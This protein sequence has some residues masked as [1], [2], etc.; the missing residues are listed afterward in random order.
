ML[1][2]L[3]LSFSLALDAL[4]VSIAEGALGRTNKFTLGLKL[5]LV[6]GFF[7]AGM[8]MLG[9]LITGVFVEGLD[10]ID[11]WI[12]FII[13]ILLGLKMFKEAFEKDKAPLKSLSWKVLCLLGIATS[14]DALAA[15]LTLPML[16]SP[17]VLSIALVGGVTFVLCYVGA[18]FGAFLS[19]RF[20]IVP[21]EAVGGVFLMVLGVN[22]LF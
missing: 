9:V 6:F 5:A 13:F 21:L 18:V 14:I 22:A 3:I 12:A 1:S 8:S 10:K 16:D 11:H 4:S 2:A 19:A 20:K 17:V 15:G 7:Q